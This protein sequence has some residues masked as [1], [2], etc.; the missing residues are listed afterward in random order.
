MKIY[1]EDIPDE[2]LT[3]KV[4]SDSD[5]WLQNLLEDCVEGNFAKKDKAEVC[6]TVIN[7]EGNLDL[8]G[9]IAIFTH[10]VCDRCLE[11]Y[12]DKKN[13][14]FHVFMAPLKGKGKDKFRENDEKELIKEDLD[15]G[16]YEGDHIDL[17]EIVK[18]QLVLE[19]PIKKICKE[20]CAGICQKCGCNLNKEKCSC[21]QEQYDPR[22]DAL[23]G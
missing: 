11:I 9:D 5:K 23:K 14:E 18:E 7:C 20:D 8:R 3:I 2:G 19:R 4:D 10:P 12:K 17:S 13:I 6:V 21:K 1:I 15:F 16:F 22:W